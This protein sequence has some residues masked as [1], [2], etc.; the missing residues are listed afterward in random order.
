MANNSEKEKK[1]RSLIQPSKEAMAEADKLAVGISALVGN[2][3]QLYCQLVEGK[4]QLGF[5]PARLAL[6]R[7][8][9][10]TEVGSSD[11][12]E[13]MV[14]FREA[15]RALAG[16]TEIAG[17]PINEMQQRVDVLAA[18]L[19]K[20]E[21]LARQ[22]PLMP[23]GVEWRNGNRLPSV[24]RKDG[25]VFDK[26]PRNLDSARDMG[27][28]MNRQLSLRGEISELEQ[29]IAISQYQPGTAL[30]RVLAL[31]EMAG[32]FHLAIIYADAMRA[33]KDEFDLLLKDLVAEEV[34][35]GGKGVMAGRVNDAFLKMEDRR[36]ALAGQIKANQEALAGFDTRAVD[37]QTRKTNMRD[38]SQQID[39]MAK[40]AKDYNDA[41]IT[42][43]QG[44]LQMKSLAMGAVTDRE[45]ME[46]YLTGLKYYMT[47]YY[48]QAAGL[49]GCLTG[50][51]RIV[52]A[53][54][55]E[56]LEA[57]TRRVMGQVSESLGLVED[58]VAQVTG[59]MQGLMHAGTIL[60]KPKELP[61]TDGE[62]VDGEYKEA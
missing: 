41:F 18:L 44:M 38:A 20:Q 10:T 13:N 60:E 36:L 31:P 7:A 3:T 42:T 32:V 52:G 47:I 5:D 48:M 57:E 17:L 27:G 29:R 30:E 62:V 34:R 45:M 1:E 24:R 40:A 54:M 43:V 25:S 16:V 21:L 6:L 55:K 61:M 56:Y 19:K 35:L 12:A 33:T 15:L 53:G 8:I 39:S 37:T 51:A 22:R 49:A 4:G 9:E 11:L 14:D 26:M 59:D 46:I 58:V 23:V 2:G 50:A 28:E